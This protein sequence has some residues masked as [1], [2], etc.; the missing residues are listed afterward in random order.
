MQ[1]RIFTYGKLQSGNGQSANICRVENYLGVSD[2][3]GKRIAQ[4]VVRNF[5]S[6]FGPKH[7]DPKY[8]SE[9]RK[10]FELHPLPR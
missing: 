4:N 8:F 7:L 6:P 3:N 1:F 2:E 10:L 9:Q 5:S